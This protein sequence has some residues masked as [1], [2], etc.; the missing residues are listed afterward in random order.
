MKRLFS[1]LFIFCTILISCSKDN[2]SSL[3]DNESDSNSDET[4]QIPFEIYER[5]YGVMSD[6]Y[7]D[8][9]WVYINVNSLPDHGS[10]YYEE[11]V[12]Q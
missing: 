8:D 4:T 3:N 7:Q 10:P 11:T 6:I 1:L 12:T 5:V 9:N 2:S